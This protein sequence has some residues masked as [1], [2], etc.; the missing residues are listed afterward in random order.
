MV[1][2]GSP[3]E[4]PCGKSNLTPKTPGKHGLVDIDTDIW[5][6]CHPVELQTHET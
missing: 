4:T 5:E 1:T 6:D 3:Q 2:W